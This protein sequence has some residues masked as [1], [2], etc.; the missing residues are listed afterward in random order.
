MCE[1]RVRHN[2]GVARH[3]HPSYGLVRNSNQLSPMRPRIAWNHG[4]APMDQTAIAL[5]A[6]ALLCII[7]LG[8]GVAIG[9]KLGRAA[10]PSLV[11]AAPRFEQPTEHRRSMDAML[12]A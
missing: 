7:V 1:R 8:L 9:L 6:G 4:L 10:G 5:L 12:T 3:F 11:I 2:V